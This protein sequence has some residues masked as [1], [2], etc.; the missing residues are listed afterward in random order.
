MCSMIIVI[1]ILGYV[2]YFGYDI[3]RGSLDKFLVDVIHHGFGE[4]KID[5]K[6]QKDPNNMFAPMI[7]FNLY[8][9]I[10]L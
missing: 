7:S 4:E 9:D 2:I 8:D 10:D 3:S 6:N 1:L 5:F